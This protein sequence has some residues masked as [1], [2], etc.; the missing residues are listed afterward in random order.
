MTR[1]NF[2][3]IQLGTPVSKFEE[4]VG[5]P[6][7]ITS[8]K[9]GSEEYEYIERIPLGDEIVEENHYFL[10]IKEG[11]VISKRINRERP[12]AYDLIYDADPNDTD[13]Q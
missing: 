7:K 4:K 5:E 10:I 12:P 13:L 1:Q 6:Y 9:E 8:L 2:D 11:K 3:E